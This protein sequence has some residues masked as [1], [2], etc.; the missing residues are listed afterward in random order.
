MALGSGLPA[1]GTDAMAS[2]D[3]LI[4]NTP[5]V[6]LRRVASPAGARVLAKL[7]YFNPGGSVKDRP[8]R[9]II[10]AAER[11]GRLHGGVTLLDASSGN[12]GIAYAML[13]AA[14]GI[15]IDQCARGARAEPDA[16]ERLRDGVVQ[17]A[18]QPL[19]FLKGC[20]VLRLAV[21]AMV[22]QSDGGLVGDRR[23]H[24]DFIL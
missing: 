17:L 15:P 12:T 2:L 22:L 19:P 23:Q 14:L 18:R 1:V 6:P 11:D 8:A 4:G 3:R 16:V 10:R 20:R 13:G 7:E 21:Q 9:E 24:V 5:L